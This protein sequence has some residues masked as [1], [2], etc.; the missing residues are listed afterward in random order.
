MISIKLRPHGMNTT[1]SPNLL[2]HNGKLRLKLC[3]WWQVMTLDARNKNAPVQP[4]YGI[5]WPKSWVHNIVAGSKLRKGV[6]DEESSTP[7]L[8]ILPV[9]DEEK[10][11]SD[12]DVQ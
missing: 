2:L 3:Q 12:S 6:Y 8:E 5:C 10:T 4:I 11:C 9:R 1:H 7:H